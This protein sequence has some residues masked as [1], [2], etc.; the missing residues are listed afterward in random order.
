MMPQLQIHQEQLSETDGYYAKYL[1]N[2][3]LS[4]EVVVGLRI[5]SMPEGTLPRLDTCEQAVWRCDDPQAE[6]Y[7]RASRICNLV[8]ACCRYFNSGGTWDEIDEVLDAVRQKIAYSVSVRECHFFDA[9]VAANG[10]W[11]YVWC[12]AAVPPQL[13]VW[14]EDV[15][16]WS[17]LSETDVTNLITGCYEDDEDLGSVE[18]VGVDDDGD[19]AE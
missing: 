9:R 17:A 6:D 3:T 12:S 18:N 11:T 8:Q 14:Q 7:G 19:T 4:L 16:V 13:L 5:E 10:A 1:D 2:G 15:G